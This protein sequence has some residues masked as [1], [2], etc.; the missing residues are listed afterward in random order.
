MFFNDNND[1]TKWKHKKKLDKR[2]YLEL[3]VE[4]FF[5]K[6]QQNQ[7]KYISGNFPKLKKNWCY[8]IYFISRW[9]EILYFRSDFMMLWKLNGAQKIQMEVSLAIFLTL[10][11][12]L[13]ILSLEM[14]S[15]FFFSLS[16][17]LWSYSTEK[18]YGGFVQ[19][20]NFLKE[21]FLTTDVL[22]C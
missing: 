15:F 11:I 18:C 9:N 4:F 19:K 13:M 12:S 14:Q 3:F 8:V 1:I 21:M 20:V 16:L 2:I 17:L 5:L 10:I 6:G 22:Q 7:P